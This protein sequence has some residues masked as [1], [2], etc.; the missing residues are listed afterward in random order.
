[1]INNIFNV[2]FSSLVGN[3]LELP[4]FGLKPFSTELLITKLNI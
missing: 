4:V 3:V 2:Y 1:M